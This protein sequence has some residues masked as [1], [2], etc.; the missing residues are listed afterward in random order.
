[1][2]D[3]TLVPLRVRVQT[4]LPLRVPVFVCVADRLDKGDLVPT[5]VVVLLRVLVLVACADRL[6]VREAGGV[7]DAEKLRET[8]FFGV[9]WGDL[10]EAEVGKA[11]R[12]GLG[13]EV[14]VTAVGVPDEDGVS[15]VN[16]VA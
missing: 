13:V 4:A 12:D 14:P 6:G 1:M 9:P 5:A 15:V 3:A 2:D 10:V 7:R 11:V 16:A 8:V